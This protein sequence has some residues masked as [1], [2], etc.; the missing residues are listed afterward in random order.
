[1]AD[2]DTI[3]L[4]AERNG[5]Y[6]PVQT[7]NVGRLVQQGFDQRFM[8]EWTGQIDQLNVLPSLCDVSTPH[9]DRPEQ[10]TNETTGGKPERTSRSRVE[11]VTCLFATGQ[12]NV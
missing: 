12:S 6:W 4:Y 9:D 5:C 7:F 1:M 8:L 10:P 3:T 11:K 2:F